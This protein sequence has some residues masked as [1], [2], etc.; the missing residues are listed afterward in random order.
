MVDGRLQLVASLAILALSLV[1]FN[2]LLH[3]TSSHEQELLILGLV[4]FTIILSGHIAHLI[5]ISASIIEL[6][7]GILIAAAGGVVTEPLAVLAGIGANIL[8]FM[9]GS[10][11]DVRMLRQRI[12]DSIILGILGFA[13]PSI[14][15]YVVS[16]YYDLPLES[17]LLLIAG[18]SATSVAITYSILRSMGLLSSRYGQV[19][20]SAAMIADVVGMLLLNVASASVDPKL[21]AYALILVSALALQPLIPRISGAPFEAEIRLVTM[22]I[23]VLGVLSEI[24]GVHSVLTSF[25]LGIVVSETVRSK[26]M[27]REKLEGLATGFF[28][29]FFFISSGMKVNP[30]LLLNDIAII[31]LVGLAVFIAKF[32]PP[33]LYFR[34]AKRARRRASIILSSSLAPLLTVS[35]I[36]G[37]VGVSLGLL[38]DEA[39]NI[40]MGVVLF[41]VIAS[42]LIAYNYSRR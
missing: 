8:L 2:K 3:L 39:Y 7:V 16:V 17:T 40:L 38:G 23:I 29:P 37:E 15:G 6:M 13:V 26:R 19:A 35:I 42:S 25:I 32:L 41:S 33:F 10:E 11:V 30:N 21:I 12:G 27:L 31:V 18:F 22:A 34:K 14:V 28:T 24:V 20:L 9:A 5:G 4:A 36:S 1:L